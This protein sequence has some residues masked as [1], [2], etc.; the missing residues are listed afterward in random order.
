MS[1]SALDEQRRDL[2]KQIQQCDPNSH[3]YLVRMGSLLEQLK[4]NE[5]Q[6]KQIQSGPLPS[7]Q[8]ISQTPRK[9]SPTLPPHPFIANPPQ[10]MD[11][12]TN[13]SLSGINS[14]A[15]SASSSP[16]GG[17]S[18]P[19]TPSA[20]PPTHPFTSTN[21]PVGHSH[22]QPHLPPRDPTTNNHWQ[23]SS[24]YLSTPA[25][26]HSSFA[27]RPTNGSLLDHQFKSPLN[28][29]NGQYTGRLMDQYLS[30]HSVPSNTP[31]SFTNQQNN[32]SKLS[33]NPQP[34]VIEILDDDEIETQPDPL[35]NG[36]P[37][38]ATAN[39]GKYDPDDG[40]ADDEIIT[41]AVV[42]KPTHVSNNQSSLPTTSPISS[43][44]TSYDE[45]RP[46]TSAPYL[47]PYNPV[48][49]THSFTRNQP[50]SHGPEAKRKYSSLFEQSHS[51]G[52][53]EDSTVIDLTEDDTPTDK[54]PRVLMAPTAPHPSPTIY[55][56]IYYKMILPK[57]S[58]ELKKYAQGTIKFLHDQIE[59]TLNQSRTANQQWELIDQQIRSLK[60]VA[61]LTYM[62]NLR[63]M[64]LMKSSKML[65]VQ[66]AASSKNL[67]QLKKM[68]DKL[69]KGGV[70]DYKTY[71]SQVVEMTR[72]G[73]EI[74]QR[75]IE[76]ISMSATSSVPL[77]PPTI[78][79][80]ESG[81][82]FAPENHRMESMDSFG[83]YGSEMGGLNREKI[84]KLLDNIQADIDI[85]P[86][87]R[88]GT[89][90]ELKITLLEHQKLGLTWLQKME[91]NVK[92][93]ILADDMGL[94]KTIQT[95]YAELF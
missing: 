10:Q 50:L 53:P 13:G 12:E 84:E 78:Q 1:L 49:Q 89:P 41:S 67:E 34:E 95:M 48:A 24:Q 64:S 94:G 58:G 60:R 16:P 7:F 38:R 31:S 43:F 82:L 61:N 21:L 62:D 23:N 25:S 91:K 26:P 54:R 36:E 17:I 56:D 29:S 88:R 11:Q 28:P 74:F 15:P 27:H 73:E 45:A 18:T 71:Y 44:N 92:G 3:D 81:S 65:W 69:Y 32:S 40:F 22:S 75:A 46:I 80:T 37:L 70:A 5:N 9:I 47:E 8:N 52:P 42:Q 35:P 79:R 33:F 14:S 2:T 90:E 66:K 4:N 93:G 59:R 85:K 6:I 83:S 87:D 30:H 57:L 86:A 20:F 68:A 19:I 39:T 76:H 72:Q 55:R 63:L 51:Q 77:Q